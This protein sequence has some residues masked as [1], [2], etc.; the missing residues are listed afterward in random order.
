MSIHFNSQSISKSSS[1]ISLF[2]GISC[3]RI[4]KAAFLGVLFWTSGAFAAPR[5][6]CQKSNTRFL[7]NGNLGMARSVMPQAEGRVLTQYLNEMERNGVLVE[8]DKVSPHNL[9]PIQSEINFEIVRTMLKSYAKGEY[10]PCA[11]QILVQKNETHYSVMDGHHR[12]SACRLLNRLQS[13]IVVY[14]NYAFDWLQRFPGISRMSLD[15]QL[16]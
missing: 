1:S 10:N 8:S 7:C 2:K 5:D 11:Q 16:L 15:D 12:W 6:L 14:S 3:S 13:V 9:V 4:I